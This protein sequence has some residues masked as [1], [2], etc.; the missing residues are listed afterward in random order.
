MILYKYSNLAFLSFDIYYRKIPT[1]VHI[2]GYILNATHQG[3]GQISHTALTYLFTKYLLLFIINDSYDVPG[4]ILDTGVKA[5]N[6][7]DKNVC[8]NGAYII[9]GR[10]R[11]ETEL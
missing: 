11:Q 3:N 10:Q 6:K 9:V 7:T 1:G 8:L 4:T 5:L 2:K